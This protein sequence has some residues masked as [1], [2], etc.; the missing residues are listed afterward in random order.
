LAAKYKLP[1][2]AVLDCL[3]SDHLPKFEVFDDYTFVIFRM[4]DSAGKPN[5]SNF[6][7][8]TRKLA[9]FF[10]EKFLLT[11]HRSNTDIVE[12]VAKKYCGD[13][14]VKTPFDI[15]CK[16]YKNVLETFQIPLRDIDK[17]VDV[18]E[19]NIFLKKRI[20]DL[21]KTLYQ[22]KR[23]AYLIK[24]LNLINKSVIEALPLN[25]K[26]SPYYSDMHDYFVSIDTLTEE[27]YDSI[28][29]I[30][31]LYLAISSQKTN[32]VMRILTAF[33]AF[34]LPLTFIVGV[35]GM[36][37]A[38]M[39]ELDMHWAYPAVLGVMAIITIGIY[40]WFRRRGWLQ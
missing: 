21:L 35:Y 2:P 27:I 28:N 6:Q 13:T 10:N 20:P 15:V 37:F 11:I 8:L 16:I 19:Q 7:Q 36:N 31:H 22:I 18:Y 29:S 32:E 4:F 39:P 34:F 26:R 12:H 17:Q 9:I 40:I 33:S 14:I 38:Y 24:R 1:A 23:K 25:H 5:P 30:L 3:Q